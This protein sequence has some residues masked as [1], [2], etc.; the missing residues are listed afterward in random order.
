MITARV[1]LSQLQNRPS[2]WSRLMRGRFGRLLFKGASWFSRR[3]HAP[4][5]GQ[6]TIAVLG[7]EAESLFKA[8]PAEV[9]N[10]LHD[11]PAVLAAL[12]D[13]AERLRA[14][15]REGAEARVSGIVAAM[16]AVRLELMSMG[17]GIASL[18]DVTRNL[19][20]ARRIA[21]RVDAALRSRPPDSRS[22]L[23]NGLS[24]LDTPA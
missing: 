8:L 15:D 1:V 22:P 3:Q 16:E 20:Q 4:G 19:E 6:P 9:R 14:V 7:M 2:L 24:G 10:Q 12:R 23:P 11:L 13:K 21:E 17:A 5:V 18:P